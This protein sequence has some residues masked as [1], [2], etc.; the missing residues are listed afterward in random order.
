MKTHTHS[1]NICRIQRAPGAVRKLLPKIGSFLLDW[2]VRERF[3]ELGLGLESD[4]NVASRNLTMEQ[5]PD[6][7]LDAVVACSC[8][9][10]VDY[11]TVFN[12]IVI[13]GDAELLW[14]PKPR[15]EAAAKT[16]PE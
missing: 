6:R 1:R 15:A 4:T 8:E 3:A 16:V 2:K 7:R 12:Y 5:F 9:W 10:H 14:C 13:Q 11:D